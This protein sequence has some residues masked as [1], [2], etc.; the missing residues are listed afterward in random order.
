[1]G[2]LTFKRSS[3]RADYSAAM[4]HPDRP[5]LDNRQ[6]AAIVFW[7]LLTLALVPAFLWLAPASR[8]D[9]PV[10]IATL[11]VLSVIAHHSV[12]PL[13]S[14]AEFDAA[15]ALMLICVALVGPLPALG[16]FLAPALVNAATRQKRFLRVATLGNFASVGWQAIGAAAVLDALTGNGASWWQTSAGLL[17]AGVV[18]FYVGWAIGPAIWAPLW[19]DAPVRAMFDALQDMRVAA[20]VMMALG[21]ITVLAS[22]ALG[23]LALALFAVVAV[24][25][26]SALTYAAR[27]RPVAQLDPL[28]ATRR[29]AAAIAVHL[30]LDR[31]Q[32]RELDA[33]ARI[34]HERAA[35]GDPTEHL[36]HTVVD[37]SE[38]SCAAGHVTEWWNGT[39][40]PAGVPGMI[41]P[42]PA[43]IVAVA[44]TWAAL[45]AEGSP[46]LAHADALDHLDSAAGVRFDPRVVQAARIV[47]AQERRTE[48]V[49]A[50]EPRLHHLRVPAP[51]RR[52]L[53]AG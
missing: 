19:A 49:P 23:L 47:I 26:Q 22:P 33:V 25:P 44:Q 31:R 11:L 50:P 51:L 41:I 2:V 4:S 13:P 20:G 15:I 40:G 48:A 14:G 18:L 5:R 8:W 24:L 53:A 17:G 52:A 21:A 38:I 32:R 35:S 9:D 37:W 1:V 6:R 7:W 16:V 34:A 45:T 28:T 30:R 39:G 36:A 29:Y 3:A 46:R 42:L 12:V 43:R 27:T 10:L